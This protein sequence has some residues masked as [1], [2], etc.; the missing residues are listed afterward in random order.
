[1]SSFL[2][3]GGLKESTLAF[4]Q[5]SRLHLELD[6]STF[7]GQRRFHSFMQPSKGIKGLFTEHDFGSDSNYKEIC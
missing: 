2:A 4:M 3:D 7:A 5:P 1:M 6:K